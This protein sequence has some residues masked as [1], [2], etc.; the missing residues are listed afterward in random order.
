MLGLGAVL[1]L[2]V[3]VAVSVAVWPSRD[4]LNGSPHLT[5]LP[6]LL[7]GVVGLGLGLL[8]FSAS[9]TALLESL[10][11]RGSPTAHREAE[12]AKAHRG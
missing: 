9:V 7:V 6:L 8:L 12:T 5:G 2:A 1:I 4:A 11:E 3:S 10:Y